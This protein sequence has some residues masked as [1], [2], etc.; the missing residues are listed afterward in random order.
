MIERQFLQVTYQQLP[1]YVEAGVRSGNAD[2]VREAADRL[3]DFATHA[4]TPWIR[5][6]SARS[7][8]LLAGDDQAEELYVEAIAQ[9]TASTVV[10]DA[11]RAHLLYGE[12]LR[13]AKRRHDAREQLR[14][15]LSI[16]E[17]CRAP[18]FAARARRELEATGL[19]SA[20]DAPRS[21]DDLTS[22]ESAVAR[23]AATGQTNLEIGA[24]LF[25][26]VNTVDYHLRK[27]FRKL[28]VTSRRQLS[29]RFPTDGPVTTT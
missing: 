21:A 13:R 5:G 3:T 24:A 11:G 28:A 26:S 16:F 4:G 12:W 2:Q 19:R 18:S 8:A 20:A 9:L 10:A 6:L 15:A 17:R 7:A 27:V 14:K 25:I 29:E 22:Q 1:D 23:L